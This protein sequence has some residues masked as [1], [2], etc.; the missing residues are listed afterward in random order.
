M[1][2]PLLSVAAATV[3]RI[4]TFS[5]PTL[6]NAGQWVMGSALG[7]YFTPTVG[8]E[9]AGLWWVVLLYVMWSL[10][11]A[12]LIAWGLLQFHAKRKTGMPVDVLRATTYFA[13]AIGGASE[14]TLLAHSVGA[15]TDLVAT[16]QSLRMLLVVTLVPLAM[17]WA[18]SY[19]NLSA[20]GTGSL[21]A[22]PVQLPG[23]VWLGLATVA[24]GWLTNRCRVSNPWFLGPLFVAIGLTLSDVPLS[25]IP[26]EASNAAQLVIGVS[27][28]VRF[29]P[30]FL[31]AAS[32]W[33]ASVVV[34]TLCAIILSACFGWCLAT[35][36]GLHPAS[37]I[38]ATAPGGVTEMSITAKVL[39]LGVPVVTAL[40]AS[41]LVVLLIIAKPLYRFIERRHDKC[42]A[43]PP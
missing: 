39:Q 18:K 23:L 43:N 31:R 21:N 22:L 8:H 20:I 37:A 5:A 13:S 19:W 34:C 4:P 11:L 25:A 29:A 28:G 6:R 12:T 32:A 42:P 27:L 41:R 30:Q 24:G 7:L 3:S 1:L 10:L 38:L 2:G 16:A 35:V 9:L 17:L 40:Q 36:S 26:H 14:M 33:I 15:R